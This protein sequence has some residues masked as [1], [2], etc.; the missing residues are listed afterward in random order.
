[1]GTGALFLALK[2]PVRGNGMKIALASALA[3]AAVSPLATEPF[4][5][6]SVVLVSLATS[7]AILADSRAYAQLALALILCGYRRDRLWAV[8]L[9]DSLLLATITPVAGIAWVVREPVLILSYLALSTT[10]SLLVGT[11]ELRRVGVG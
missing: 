3:L 6:F 1:M 2:I 9:I 10:L 7:S 5:P 8:L 11:A 4:L